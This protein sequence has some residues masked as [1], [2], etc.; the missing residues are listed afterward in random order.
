MGDHCVVDPPR[1][2]YGRL[3]LENQ[4]RLAR[5]KT[6][7]RW[8]GYVKVFVLLM[9]ALAAIALLHFPHRLWLLLIPAAIFLCLAVVHERVL[10]RA[11]RLNRVIDFYERGVARLENRWA[12]TGE[13]G[14][15]FLEAMH[16]YARDLDLFGQGS[17][18]E[19]LCTTRTRAGE[20]TLADWLLHPAAPEVVG[21]RHEAIL[22]MK[23]RLRFRELL[24]VAGE[25]VRLGVQPEAL[26]SWGEQEPGLLG[27]WLA[28]L[29]MLA[30]LWMGAA[31]YCALSGGS[32]YALGLISLVN[33][34]ISFRI[35]RS[36]AGGVGAVEAATK[37]LRIL[38]EVLETIEK[39]PFSSELL[40]RLR[41]SLL[42]GQVVPSAA[43]RRL[44]RI[45]EWLEARRHPL[46]RVVDPFVFY[47]PSLMLAIQRW[48]RRFGPSIRGWL[49]TVGEMEAIASLAGYAAEHPNDVL[50][51]FAGEGASF[52]AQELAHPLL[53]EEHAVGNDI[54]LDRNTHLIVISGPNMAGKSTFLR[55]V[56]LNAVLAQCGAPVRARRLRLSPLAVGASICVLDSLQGGV[57]RF[58]AEIRRLKILS[59]M[60][61]G[62]MPLLF[63]LDELLSGTNSHD[64]YEGTRS[65]VRALVRQG[66]IGMVT[67]HDLALTEIP[68]LL[69]GV[70]ANY[71]FEDAIEGGQL[72]FDFRLK[73]GIVRTSNALQLMRQVGL[74][75]PG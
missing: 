47:T 18:F 71:H 11:R 26:A 8:L 4:T 5:E 67:T 53:P 42:V 32:W 14:T 37:D 45:C 3:F 69:D 50:P 39:E 25:S 15:R 6:W 10:R 68:A 58:Y 34:S 61:D 22:E 49:A 27:P 59:D 44:R 51:E 2:V 33:L 52:E 19:L 65:V 40:R 23:E 9:L 31:V 56:G 21:S 35:Y 16:P 57:S 38:V 48:Q 74:N 41:G 46:L 1:A 20:A 12:G 70:A 62:P 55:G 13:Q 66:A 36:L 24:F 29:P 28:L 63:L 17:L 64:R 60:A 75:L 73:P 43:V 72:K 30:A 7:D 54:K